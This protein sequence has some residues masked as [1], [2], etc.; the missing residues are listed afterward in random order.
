VK[1]SIKILEKLIFW[2]LELYVYFITSVEIVPN[3]K[4]L[5]DLYVDASTIAKKVNL[6]TTI[7]RAQASSTILKWFILIF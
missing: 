6:A 4:S 5:V 2:Q 3:L 1:L 7:R